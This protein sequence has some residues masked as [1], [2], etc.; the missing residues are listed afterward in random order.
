[1]IENM[2]TEVI[3]HDQV[4]SGDAICSICKDIIPLGEGEKERPCTHDLDHNECIT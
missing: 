2:A 3:N 1:M 4:V